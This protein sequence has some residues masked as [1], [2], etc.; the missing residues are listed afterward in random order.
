MPS[1]E[2]MLAL[3]ELLNQFTSAEQASRESNNPY[4][5]MLIPL[6]ARCAD[7]CLHVKNLQLEVTRLEQRIEELRGSNHGTRQALLW[8]GNRADR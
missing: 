7:L 5:K 1:K 8:D 3:T 4:L 6:L 2:A